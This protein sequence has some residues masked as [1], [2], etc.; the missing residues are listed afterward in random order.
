[1][2]TQEEGKELVDAFERAYKYYKG[3]LF[4][5]QYPGYLVYHQMG[6]PLNVFF[7]PDFSRIG[8]V[9]IQVQNE[10]GKVV[11]TETIPYV[12]PETNGV[13][14]AQAEAFALFRIVR[15]WLEKH[16]SW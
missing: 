16:G 5:Y 10:D 15:P 1:M 4:E 11:E 13:P 6:G 14:Y 3:W 12:H 2:A 8:Q 9:D 7:T